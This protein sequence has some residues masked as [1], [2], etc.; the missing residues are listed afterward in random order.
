MCFYCLLLNEINLA[1]PDKNTNKS[2]NFDVQRVL[3][4][5]TEQNSYGYF[6]TDLQPIRAD[7]CVMMN[8]AM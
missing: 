1:E 6:W 4:A 5:G 7:K 8:R 3:T 2:A